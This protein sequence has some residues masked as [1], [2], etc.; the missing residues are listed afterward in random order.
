M[1]NVYMPNI[2]V[3]P[4]TMSA[5]RRR[6]RR[7]ASDILRLPVHHSHPNGYCRNPEPSVRRGSQALAPEGKI[8]LARLLPCAAAQHEISRDR[9]VKRRAE[10]TVTQR[11]VRHRHPRERSAGETMGEV[12]EPMHDVAYRDG[13]SRQKPTRGANEKNANA[14]ELGLPRMRRS[15]EI[16][17]EAQIEASDDD[18]ERGPKN[19][20]PAS[21]E[22][23][24]EDENASD[25]AEQTDHEIQRCHDQSADEPA[26]RSGSGDQTLQ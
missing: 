22:D 6:S 9:K 7:I 4:M 8:E 3:R 17:G 18:E 21:L 2:I 25:R 26:G 1:P 14:D 11:N 20:F 12:P 23:P 16:G 10:D 13:R 19:L 15:L 5:I 24:P